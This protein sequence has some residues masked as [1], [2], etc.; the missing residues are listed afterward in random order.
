MLNDWH[1][2]PVYSY[3]YGYRDVYSIMPVD[4]GIVPP[5]VGG[6]NR[7][8]N[9][10][11]LS[12]NSIGFITCSDDWF[13]DNDVKL[14]LIPLDDPSNLQ[15]SKSINL[16]SQ[17]FNHIVK[18]G[19]SGDKVFC[20]LGRPIAENI[21]ANLLG[22]GGISDRPM[23]S[24]YIKIIDCS[25]S[26]NPIVGEPINIPGLAVG[27][28]GDTIFTIDPKWENDNINWRFCS[29]GL[30]DNEAELLDEVSLGENYPD[31]I[32][33][34][35]QLAVIV[36]SVGFDWFD[37]PMDQSI[38]GSKPT[39]AKKDETRCRLGSFKLITI[40]LRNLQ[41]LTIASNQEYAGR[42]E[43]KMITDNYLLAQNCSTT[44]AMLWKI[45]DN[46]E[47]NLRSITDIPSYINDVTF[48]AQR[49]DLS[50]GRSGIITIPK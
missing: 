39:F 43:F 37:E 21:I 9:P 11:L 20:T 18:V 49:I 6:L 28:T 42:C 46:K 30:S 22:M 12:N 32:K 47:I 5:R 16:Y 33:I 24:Y 38:Q 40:D 29:V 10:L 50:C 15:I 19:V 31:S 4:P 36:S 7:Q 41:A 23:V 48:D 1:F 17:D 34:T 3:G 45:N 26:A 8:E 25:D 2:L 27:I 35:C 44:Q 14:K 13:D